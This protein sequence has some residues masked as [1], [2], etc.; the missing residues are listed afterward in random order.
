MDTYGQNLRLTVE[1]G[2]HDPEIR[3]TL[4]GFPKGVR[5]D[6]DALAAHMKRRAPGQ[7]AWST[8]RKE[9]DV[10]VFRSGIGPDGTTDGSEIRAVICNRDPHSGDYDS[11]HDRPRPGHADYPAIRKYGPEVDLRGGGHFSGRLTA[12]LCVAGYLCETWLKEKGIYVGAHLLAVGDVRDRAY[13]P[14][15]TDPKDFGKTAQAEFPVLDTDAG[16]RMKKRIAEA[17]E[18]GDSIGGLVECAATGLPAGLG[19]HMFAGAEGRIASMLFSIPAVKG[20]EFGDGFA[21]CGLRGSENNDPYVTDGR[22][23]RT[24]SNHAGG[25]LGGMTTGMPLICRIAVKPTPSIARTQRTVSL[26]EMKNVEIRVQGRHDPCIAPRAV[27]VAES[28]LAVAVTDLML[29]L[30]EYNHG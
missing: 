28:A 29:D 15:L 26:S 4:S 6:P 19:T 23:V 20:V 2:S 22:S 3:M 10:P 14:V 8:Q 5:V 21:V 18:A 25:I 7:N 17:R 9:S 27:P 12:L 1:G 24:E 16:E 13:D 30:E 11:I